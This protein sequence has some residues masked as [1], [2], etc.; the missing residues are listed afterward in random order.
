MWRLAVGCAVLYTSGSL[1][2]AGKE[3]WGEE[4]VVQQVVRKPGGREA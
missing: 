2:A 3:E 1:A 4:R